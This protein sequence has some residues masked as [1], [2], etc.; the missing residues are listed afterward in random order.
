MAATSRSPNLN[1]AQKKPGAGHSFGARARHKLVPCA[2]QVRCCV[3]CLTQATYVTLDHGP[4]P[5]AMGFPAQPSSLEDRRAPSPP[6]ASGGT[7]PWAFRP[8]TSDA[9]ETTHR[10]LSLYVPPAGRQGGNPQDCAKIPAA[11]PSARASAAARRR[12]TPRLRACRFPVRLQPSATAEVGCQPS[13]VSFQ[14][15]VV[16]MRNPRGN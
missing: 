16:C 7:M 2:R 8:A 14:L 5:S 9:K 11:P 4:P 10:S 15:V 6:D 3:A 13:A 1:P 12:L